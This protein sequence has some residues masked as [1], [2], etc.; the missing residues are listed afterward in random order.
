M[1]LPT[2]A[3]LA[4]FFA[5][6]QAEVA[7]D[8]RARAILAAASTLIRAHTGRVWVDAD[9]ELE[10]G[11]TEVQRETVRSVCLSVA[12]RVFNNPRGDTQQI[13]GPF[14]RTIAAWA[15]LGLALTDHEKNQLSV[16][17]SSGIPGLWSARVVAPA[18]ARGTR[19]SYEWWEEDEENQLI[20]ND[21]Q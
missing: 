19:F 11:V 16:T 5:W 13:T 8:Q 15:A 21:G 20:E 4:D 6:E 7:D 18:R 3:S 17:P 1:A 10:A 12:S 9:G 14:S 2:L